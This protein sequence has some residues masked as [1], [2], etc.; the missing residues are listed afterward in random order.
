MSE[1]GQ[2]PTS[3]IHQALVRST[4][5]TGHLGVRCMSHHCVRF[6]AARPPAFMGRPG[7]NCW[8]GM[9]AHRPAAFVLAR[10]LLQRGSGNGLGRVEPALHDRTEFAQELRASVLHAGDGVA[11][12]SQLGV[13]LRRKLG[14]GLSA[15]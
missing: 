3:P 12:C 14:R 10:K 2:K 5:E 4:P 8:I 11:R 7:V 15:D 1:V 13:F 9:A 6:A